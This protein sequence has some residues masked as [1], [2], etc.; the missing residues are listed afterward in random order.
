MMNLSAATSLP[1]IGRV[2]RPL[3]A[4]VAD[5]VYWMSRYVERAEHVARMLIVNG[6]LLTDVGDLGSDVQD[7]IWLGVMR[8]MRLFGMPPGDDRMSA[9]VVRHMA[10]DPLNPGS[11]RSCIA[12]ARE[13]ARAVREIISI[14]M[15]ESL[16]RLYWQTQGEDGSA[17]SDPQ[18]FLRTVLHGSMTFQGLT[19]QT[20]AHDQRWLFIQL[21]KHLERIDV[22]CRILDTRFD[23]LSRAAD[24]LDAPD[25]NIHWMGVLRLCSSLEAYRRQH[26]ADFDPV[27]VLLFVTLEPTHPRAIRFN[28]QRALASISAIRSITQ[29]TGVDPAER[30]LGRLSADLEYAEPGEIVRQGFANYMRGIE[31]AIDEAAVAIRQTYFLQ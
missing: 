24:K 18:E 27:K 8:S 4:R 12:R 10:F 14:E 16:N 17:E 28:A 25:R 30:V 11:I 15:W 5:S 6:N 7:E 2:E 3:L 20:L 1:P 29:P 23:L 22:T 26:L 21:G 9:R 31:S 13:N 19:D